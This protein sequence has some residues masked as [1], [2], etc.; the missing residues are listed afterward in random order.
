MRKL[1]WLPL[2]A[3][4]LAGCASDPSVDG[5]TVDKSLWG[6]VLVN[7]PALVQAGPNSRFPAA[8]VEVSNVDSSEL[9]VQWKAVWFAADGTEIESITTAWNETSILPSETKGLKAVSSAQETGG[10]RF[11]LRRQK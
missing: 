10:V 4:A 7:P 3:A 9:P 11:Y 2:A 8:N 1:F 5:V 6:D